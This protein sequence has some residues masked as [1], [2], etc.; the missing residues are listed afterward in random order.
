VSGQALDNDGRLVINE[1]TS[2]AAGWLV[3]YSDAAGSPGDVLGYSAVEAGQNEEVVVLI[4][5][6]QA[7]ETLHALLHLDDG[8]AGVF[9][10]PGP[11]NPVTVDSTE[12]GATFVVDMQATMPAVSVSDQEI[13]VDGLV[14]IDQVVA[15]VSGWLV[16]Y[17][18][19]EG[20]SGDMMG[21]LPVE[22][23]VTENLS[24]S[25]NWLEAT[26]TL[27]A[28]LYEDSGEAEV[29]EV[30]T[31]DRP[32]TVNNEPVVVPFQVLLPPD[33]F[34][35]NQPVIE[36]TIVVD[37]AVSQG[38]GWLVV[39]RDEEEA[40]GNIIGW[41]SLADGVNE[42]IVVSVLA[43]AVTPVLHIIV[44]HDGATEG[45][46]DFPGDD[47]PMRFQGRIPNPYT[48][49]TDSGNYLIMRD[50]PLSAANTITVS[51]VVVDVDTWVAVRSDA[52]GV[53]GEVIGRVWLPAGV[54]RDVIVE[55]DPDLT[56]IILYVVLHIDT[57][58]SQQFD[59][60]DGVDTPLQ[61]NRSIIQVPF[62]L[63]GNKVIGL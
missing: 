7:T 3:I 23:G 52:A 45:E 46:F 16:I 18:E 39:Y 41:A 12:V 63:N 56:T 58:P 11:D 5:P 14:I 36:G 10:Y 38:P 49:R 31:A 55:I 34:V 6:F 32:I 54:H 59:F 29:F 15:N 33:V 25:I 35:L 22:A 48:F 21:Y 43:S 1:V 30:P 51:L 37:R 53:P 9:D 27:Y 40:L 42:Q 19:E 2:A 50:Q 47:S 17:R 26:P 28:A 8:E 20:V 44:H 60:P 24:L 61:R 4:D 57:G 62:S 13:G